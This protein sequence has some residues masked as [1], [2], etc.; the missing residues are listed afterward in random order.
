MKSRG[1]K[2]EARYNR[3]KEEFERAMGKSFIDLRVE[4]PEG[5]DDVKTEFL[6]LE[7]DEDF[8]GEVEDL[9][10]KRLTLERRRKK[11]KRAMGR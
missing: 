10:R 11:R 4:I 6:N 5:F 8:H 7:K 1:R 2:S 3:D 9:V